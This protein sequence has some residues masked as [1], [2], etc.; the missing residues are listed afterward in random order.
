MS[1]SPVW[2]KRSFALCRGHELRCCGSVGDD[3][4]HGW[5]VSWGVGELAGDRQGGGRVV[6]AARDRRTRRPAPSRRD[7]SA[8]GRCK[9]DLAAQR[10]E[11]VGYAVDVDLLLRRRD[12]RSWRRGRLPFT[13]SQEPVVDG[14]VSA[15]RIENAVTN[16]S[17]GPCADAECGSPQCH[18]R[19]AESRAHV[20]RKCGANS[21]V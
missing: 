17:P 14:E 20:V 10:S 21:L 16:V 7:R 15:A 1:A 11:G 4:L 18:R 9:Q 8:V 2:P 13:A 12:D 3:H 6:H 19:F 5:E